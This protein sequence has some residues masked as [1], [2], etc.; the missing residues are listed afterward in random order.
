MYKNLL[1]IIYNPILFNLEQSQKEDIEELVESIRI[2]GVLEPLVVAETPVVT[3]SL[4]VK[5]AGVLQK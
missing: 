1:L 3:K 2:H 4:P 5:G